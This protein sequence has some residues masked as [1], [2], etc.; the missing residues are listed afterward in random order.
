MLAVALT[1][2]LA[3]A[4]AAPQGA[5]PWPVHRRT[6]DN[7][8]GV[9]LVPF[10]SPGYAAYFTFFRVGGR[11]EVEAGRS[12]LAHFFEH[13]AYR[14]TPTV[15]AARWEEETKGLGL[16]ANAF[17]DDDVTAFWLAGPASALPRVAELEGDR[18]RHLAF[19]ED[20]FQVEARAVQGELARAGGSPDYRVEAAARALAFGR[21][22]Y[23]HPALGADRDV[24]DL[25]SGYRAAL[26][27]YARHYRPENAFVLVVGDFDEEAVF[28]AVRR[29]Y[30][31]W[32]ATAPPP[33]PVPPEP[34]LARPKEAR[35]ASGPAAL[36]RLWTGWRTPG[37]G[38]LPAT[39]AQLVL[40][41][42]L[43]G[44]LSSLQRD[45]VLERVLA[46]SIG[47]EFQ[48]R[49]DPFLFGCAIVLEDAA[50]EGPARAA[51]DAAVADLAAGRVDA[52]LLADVKANVRSG[53]LMQ[54]DTAYRSG[55]WLVYHTAL[56]GD[57]GYL[58][59]LMAAAARIGADDLAAFARQALVPANRVTAVLAPAP[60]GKGGA[61]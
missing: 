56:T 45:L 33:P 15:P 19:S 38:D 7:G 47:G 30:G 36:P 41:P 25:A 3:A 61:R 24:R 16:E 10:D 8:L 34:P 22:P 40:W 17:T 13:L 60:A 14:G 32:K 4:P 31:P 5:Y 44:R 35:Q 37:A 39:A 29:A 54:T 11:D 43:F 42:Y 28:E 59:A 55:I 18:F 46:E 48:P 12:G 9:L 20:D 21:H 53:L 58:D 27:F 57:P 23:R 50:A 26:E 49:R 1:L 52:A 51:V 6:L 2:T